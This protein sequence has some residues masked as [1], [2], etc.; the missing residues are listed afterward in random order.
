[1]YRQVGARLPYTGE[2]YAAI[3]AES[4]QEQCAQ[5]RQAWADCGAAI[6]ANSRPSLEVTLEEV[7]GCDVVEHLHMSR[8]IGHKLCLLE[9]WQTAE[10][11]S[12]TTVLK[13]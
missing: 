6:V 12:F 4:E 3:L 1:M 10:V 7:V 5:L 8:R 11:A 2:R 13:M 9:K